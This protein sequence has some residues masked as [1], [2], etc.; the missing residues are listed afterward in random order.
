M[1]IAGPHPLLPV[2]VVLHDEYLL[3]G[4]TYGAVEQVVEVQNGE[5]P[6]IDSDVEY[7]RAVEALPEGGSMLA[8]VGLDDVF[9][10]MSSSADDA[11]AEVY[12]LLAANLG[13]IASAYGSQG[14]YTRI[15]TV[16][17]LFPE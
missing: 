15:T 3:I 11:A 10:Q 9:A 5:L 7:R 17:T 6:S 8:Y 16:V 13:S 12:G 1:E 4:S 2:H 14:D